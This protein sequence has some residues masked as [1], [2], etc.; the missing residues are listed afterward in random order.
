MVSLTYFQTNHCKFDQLSST[1]MDAF[2]K[3][4]GERVDDVW[5]QT[6]DMRVAFSHVLGMSHD[7]FKEWDGAVRSGSIRPDDVV[8]YFIDSME[9]P[10]FTALEAALAEP[11]APPPG[12]H[13]VAPPQPYEGKEA[14]MPTAP[15]EGK[16][17]TP[18]SPNEDPALTGNLPGVTEVVRILSRSQ[19]ELMDVVGDEVLM[20]F[21]EHPNE[22]T[23]TWERPQLIKKVECA[24]FLLAAHPKQLAM[25]ANREGEQYKK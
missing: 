17:D 9:P 22:W 1:F 11:A 3:Y 13:Q 15:Y 23:G 19:M 7:E 25:I 6:G 20:S 12:Q 4:A 18:Q 21:E 24:M 5:Q 14:D 16:E 10:R 8:S 2:V